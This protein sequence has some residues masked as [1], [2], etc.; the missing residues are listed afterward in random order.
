MPRPVHF[1]VHAEDPDRAQRFY[2]TVFDWKFEPFGDTYRLI[3]TGT[4]GPGINGGMLRRPGPGPGPGAPMS[5]WVCTVGVDDLDAY[6]AKVQAAGGGLAM[7]RMAV[8]GVGWLAYGADT[9][10]N[11]FGMMQPDTTAK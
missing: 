9:E 6:V 11:V 7:P 5:A 2:E 8:P 4:E 1:E 10:A 3:T